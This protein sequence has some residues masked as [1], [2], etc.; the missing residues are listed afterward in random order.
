MFLAV[1][2]WTSMNHEN[3][4]VRIK[5]VNYLKK[6]STNSTA[7]D[8]ELIV[9]SLLRI[10][11]LGVSHHHLRFL[12]PDAVLGDMVT[13]PVGPAKLQGRLPLLRDRGS[14]YLAHAAAAS[15]WSIGHDTACAESTTNRANNTNGRVPERDLSYSCNS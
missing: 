8:I 12:R 5:D 7:R 1:I 6:S 15:P 9:A 11:R 3:S 4:F 10:R 14:F 2:Q 13:I